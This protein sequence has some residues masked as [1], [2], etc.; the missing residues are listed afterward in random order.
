[1]SI[2]AGASA[3]DIAERALALAGPGETQV[4]VV[5]ERS[6]VSRFA[7]SAPTQ[8]TAVED[9]E[10]EILVVRDGHTASASTNR[11][12]DDALRDAAR[13]AGAA[14]RSVARS[15]A[16]PYPGL[17]EPD[18]AGGAAA[19]GSSRAR[20][21]DAATARLDPADAGTAL[22]A[23]FAVAAEH[24][25]EAF[26]IWTAG[27]VRTVIA[28][29]TGLRRDEQVTDAFMKVVCRDD[30]G[31]SGFAAALARDA[32]GKVGPEALAELG[33]GAYPVVLEPAAVGALLEFLG[34]LAFNGLAHAEGRSALSGRLGTAVAAPTIDL[35][36]DPVAA[37]TLPRGFDFEGVRKA[38]LTLIEGG[39][40]RAVVHDRRSAALMGRDV[41]STGHATRPA[42]ASDGPSPS[43]L[44]LAGGDAADVAELLAPIERGIYVTRLW[45]VNA[46]REKETLLT[47]MTR[48]G[49]FLV[50]DGAITRPLR[51][52]RFTDSVL[53]LLG[54]TE[55]LTTARQLASEGDFYGRRFAH[56]VLCP[57]LRAGGF[58]VTGP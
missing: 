49:T 17:L 31:R 2:G 21:F 53:R 24:G 26:G 19:P 57:A 27:A 29:S 13:R 55:A 3:R 12:D 28:S 10:V 42:G 50:E 23:A 41:R 1:M 51:D 5:R 6:L 34:W 16:G 43:N 25:L 37:G 14:A 58:R 22:A 33:P 48:D 36:D 52:V 54:A 40:A 38:P 32:A 35:A 46:V 15:G 18:A 30:D 56:G 44:V 45:Y 20:G 47:G 7:R 8:A 9:T 11:L 39:V 4:T